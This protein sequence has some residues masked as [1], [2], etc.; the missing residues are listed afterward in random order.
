MEWNIQISRQV[1]RQT[2]AEIRQISSKHCGSPIFSLA[3]N[4]AWT[5]AKFLS[6]ALELSS[7]FFHCGIFADNFAGLSTVQ[8]NLRG[9]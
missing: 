7:E 8:S 1:K 6:H 2:S 3:I 4:L 9:D 5:R